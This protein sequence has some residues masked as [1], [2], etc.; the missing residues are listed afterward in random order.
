MRRESHVFALAIVMAVF[1]ATARTFQHPGIDCSRADIER[2]QAMVAAGREPW[3]S[4]FTALKASSYSEP[5]AIVPDYGKRLVT[6]NCNY[7]LGHAG[8]RAHDLALMW[9]LTREGKYAAK[10]IEFLNAS[11][12]YDTLD[13]RGTVPLDYGKVFL[14]IEAA[15]LMRDHPGWAAADRE[16]FA[17]M[18]REKF[19]PVL[20]NGD[21]GRFGNQGLFAWR[22]VLAMSVFLEDGKMY[23]RVWRYLTGM[24]HRPDDEPFASGPP[25][26]DEKPVESTPQMDTFR[27]RGRSD[28][29][30]DY[31]Y[32]E[33]LRHYIYA[34][35]QCQESSR[36]QAHVMA[37]LFMYVAIAETFWLQGDDLY[38]ALG[39]R[40]LKG[41]EWS[42]R[43]NLSEWKPA[44]FTDS[45]KDA[46]FENG[47]FYRA[48]HRSGRWRSLA[49]SDNLRG[50]LG[51]D[52]AP[53]ECAYSHYRIRMGMDEQSVEWLGKA[54]ETMN[55]RTG[56]FETWG[57]PPNW[58]YEWSGWGTLMKRRTA[59]MAG[60]PPNG[61][62]RLPCRIDAKDADVNPARKTKPSYT[63]ASAFGRDYRL[64]VSYRSKDGAKIAFSCDRSRPVV[65][66]LP[67]CRSVGT[68]GCGTIHMPAGAS[69]VRW[70]LI[71]ESG[72]AEIDSF[73]LEVI[74]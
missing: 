6:E 54:M 58:F 62:H 60:D 70:T 15:E 67:P 27:L 35:G 16:C 74:R 11:S 57:N 47:L 36:D 20:K 9:H 51:T 40:I 24:S 69:V 14:L 13:L 71:P 12:H 56:G 33:Q 50:A 39:S 63:V 28:A 34:N 66:V 32:D 3:A 43:Y 18:L 42:C 25:M 45:E 21:P 2:A 10:A 41:L 65:A 38:G 44:G 73:A 68:A 4:A 8:R 59:W 48:R 26:C 17:R 30:L 19:Y 46:T 22:A 37:G 53:R 64:S 5:Y 52:G 29:V 72:Q 1:C 61:I 7:T 49:P 55:C 31:G 23:D